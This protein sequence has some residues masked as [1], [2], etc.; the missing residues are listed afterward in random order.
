MAFYSDILEW[1]D[2][3]I[4]MRKF[5]ER[6]MEKKDNKRK[7]KTKDKRLMRLLKANR[8]IVT[9][10]T[11]TRKHKSKKDYNRKWKEVE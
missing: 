6:Q 9:F 11:G 4:E 8:V 5:V 2:P 10:N 1:S 7:Q 3:D